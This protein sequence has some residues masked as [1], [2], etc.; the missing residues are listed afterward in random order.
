[1]S[2]LLDVVDALT[3]PRTTRH[4][5][6]NEAG[7]TCTTPIEHPPLLDQLDD[8]IRGTIGIGGSGSLPNE[9]NMLNN[10]ALYKSVLIT[11]LIRDWARGANV[12][13]RPDSKPR[14]L[15]RRWYIAFAQK[16]ASREVE[17]VYL[18]QMG[19]WL[20][21]IQTMFDPPR[22]QDL[23]GACPTCGAKEWWQDGQRFP[24]PLVITFHE[25]PDM[26][27]NGKGMCRAC[28]AVFGIREL[29]YAIDAAESA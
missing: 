9:R 2:E 6:S 17:G 12:E 1:M 4:I 29:S 16:P 26:I 25:G 10:E 15:L 7:I 18:R 19:V 24:R 20:G 22:T 23:P 28:E 21:Q 3:L 13:V 5:Q 14:D 27:D 11:T 8:A